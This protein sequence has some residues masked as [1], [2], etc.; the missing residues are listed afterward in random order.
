ML[1]ICLVV[2]FNDTTCDSID[3]YFQGFKSNPNIRIFMT[4][5]GSC[6][7]YNRT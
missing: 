7:A 6:G 5:Y 4:C 1:I 3:E 2:N